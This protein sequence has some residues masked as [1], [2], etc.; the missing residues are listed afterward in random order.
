LILGL[1]AVSLCGAVVAAFRCNLFVRTS[2][3]G[4]PLQ[5]ASHWASRLA[6]THLIKDVHLNIFSDITFTKQDK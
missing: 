2:Q 5:S 1:W 4:F 3:K 6:L